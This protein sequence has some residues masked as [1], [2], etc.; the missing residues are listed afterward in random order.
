MTTSAAHVGNRTGTRSPVQVAAMV[1]G[2]VFLLVGILGF[3][4]G[5][6]TNYGSLQ[7]AGHHSEAF[8]LGIF[9]VSMLH[10]IVHLLYGIVGL[11]AA[12]SGPASSKYLLIGGIIYAVLW[13]YGLVVAPDSMANLVPLNTADNWLHLAL[14]IGMVAMSFLPG[15]KLRA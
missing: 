1:I 10:N 15:R 12:K 2:A 6:T 5:I 11:T 13:I 3:I 8:L 7:F 4:P 14:F 9:Q